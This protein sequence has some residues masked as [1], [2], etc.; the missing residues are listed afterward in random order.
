MRWDSSCSLTS[1]SQTEPKTFNTAAAAAA[2]ASVVLAN[3]PDADRLAAAE[4][5]GAGGYASF[6]GN[7]I[8]LLLA[9]W[10]AERRH[11]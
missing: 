10:W 9:D 1:D 3:D 6:S 5:H 7:D 2:G 11:L 4:A 8:G